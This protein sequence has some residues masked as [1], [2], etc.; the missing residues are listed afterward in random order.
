M[1]IYVGYDSREDIAYEVCKYSIHK[2]NPDIEVIPLKL[3][4]LKEIG[5]YT[6]DIDP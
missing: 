4:A 6:R 2:Q 3:T 1:R 5:V